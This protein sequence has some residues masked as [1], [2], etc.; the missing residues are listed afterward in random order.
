MVIKLE[1]SYSYKMVY[2][3]I[4]LMGMIYGATNE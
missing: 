2:D 1:L 3:I 4:L